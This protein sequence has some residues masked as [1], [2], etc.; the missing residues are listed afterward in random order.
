[1]KRRLH[2]LAFA[3]LAACDPVDVGPDANIAPSL[4]VGTGDVAFTSFEDGDTLELVR[5]AQGAQHVWVALRAS[6]IDPR[7]TILNLALTRDRDGAVVSQTFHVR[8]SLTPVEGERYAEV[9]G[10]TLVVPDPAQALL[11]DLTLR[12][13]VTEQESAGGRMAT[14]ERR[15]RVAWG[16]P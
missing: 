16:E 11:E 10:L 4:E 15:V 13:T 5:G 6:G 7:G 8:V 14:R 3:L 12:A 2:L 1:M 9:T